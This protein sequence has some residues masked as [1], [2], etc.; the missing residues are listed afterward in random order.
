VTCDTNCT[1]GYAQSEVTSDAGGYFPFRLSQTDET[2]IGESIDLSSK[3][4][5]MLK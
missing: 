2:N 1:A 5:H 3:P 4:H